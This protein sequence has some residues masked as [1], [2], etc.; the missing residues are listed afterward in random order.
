M[1]RQ[2]SKYI[3]TQAAKTNFRTLAQLHAHTCTRTHTCVNVQMNAA[4]THKYALTH[5]YT[6]THKST[7]TFAIFDFTSTKYEVVQCRHQQICIQRFAA[8][9]ECQNGVCPNSCGATGTVR[10]YVYTCMCIL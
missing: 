6:L 2:L 7:L 3:H 5:K 4:I 10:I 8:S 9:L 1:F